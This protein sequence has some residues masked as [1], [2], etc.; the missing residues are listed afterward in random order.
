MGRNDTSLGRQPSPAK[1]IPE[2]ADH[3]INQHFMFVFAIARENMAD[4]T[5]YYSYIPNI[6]LEFSIKQT[7]AWAQKVQIY[8]YWL[9]F[10]P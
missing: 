9:I 5:G 3:C 2:G 8:L 4:K 6:V 10:P 7:I 1:G